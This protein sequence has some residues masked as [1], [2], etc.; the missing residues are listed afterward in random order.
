MCTVRTLLRAASDGGGACAGR[1]DVTAI[2]SPTFLC[3]LVARSH[4]RPC[5]GI[6]FFSGLGGGLC[7]VSHIKP[8]FL[9]G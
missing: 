6:P 8:S 3:F 1:H 9:K 4:S 7:S 2:T 5:C